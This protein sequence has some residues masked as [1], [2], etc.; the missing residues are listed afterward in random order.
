MEI[1]NM[2]D[3]LEETINRIR[4]DVDKF[5]INSNNLAGTRIRKAMQSIKVKA[6]EIRV[7]ITEIKNKR[8]EEK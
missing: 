7:T 4:T 1:R 3:D 5:E 6:Q 8:K 2:L